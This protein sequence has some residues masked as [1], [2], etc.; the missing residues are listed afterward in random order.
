MAPAL[1]RVV[2]F[3]WFVL[4]AEVWAQEPCPPTEVSSIGGTVGDLAVDGQLAYAA[5]GAGGLLVLD[6][7]SPAEPSQLARLEIPGGYAYAL[8]LG[9]A[10]S[11]GLC[12]VADY[13]G[14]LH[15]LDVADPHQPRLLATL[16]TAFATLDVAV[17][18]DLL[19]VAEG[20]DGFAVY[21]I[22]T[23]AVPVL[24]SRVSTPGRALTVDARGSLAV[25]TFLGGSPI[26]LSIENPSSATVLSTLDA[27]EFGRNAVLADQFAY[28]TGNSSASDAD[29]W[30]FDLSDPTMPLETSRTVLRGVV[31]NLETRGD[32]LLANVF[33]YLLVLDRSEPARPRLIEEFETGSSLT[34]VA[35]FG[36]LMLAGQPG[37]VLAIESVPTPAVVGRYDQFENSLV[38]RTAPDGDRLLTAAQFQ[39]LGIDDPA[40]PAFIGR[41]A[42][43]ANDVA[44]DGRHA[45]LAASYG[46]VVVDLADPA[47]PVE[48]GFA[49]VPG[50]PSDSYRV[51][52][53]GDVVYTLSLDID[54]FAL[55]TVTTYGVADPTNPVPLGS[56]AGLGQAFDMAVR[57]D[58]IVVADGPLR[59]IDASDPTDLR[60]LGELDGSYIGVVI[61]GSVAYTLHGGPTQS[62]RLVDIADPANPTVLADVPLSRAPAYL[63]DLAIVDDVAYVV[64][65][66]VGLLRVDVKDP[67]A[68]A[69]LAPAPTAGEPFAI[70]SQGTT[71]FITTT[72]GLRILH[73]DECQPCRADLDGDGELT[74]FDFLVFQDAFEAMD[75][76][77]DF[78]GDGLLTLFDFL[79]FQNAF[80]LGCG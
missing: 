37:S 3:A 56:V 60:P 21:D 5:N 46:L 6:M 15:V 36:D 52:A 45:Y 63:H 72:Q 78:D 71:L 17:A 39:M 30:T 64:G 29:L 42:L 28:V 43:S 55:S 19:L 24:R 77:A 10:A 9:R 61:G 23:P 14:G 26:V 18:G 48:V 41:T 79:A 38:G 49:A 25:V 68:P 50:W 33:S 58:L 8:A 62:L 20:V 74:I 51:H 57:D 59:T 66:E 16:P 44:A 11:R 32:R 35:S 69:I 31:D 4:V 13:Y 54:F 12:Y 22:S 34:A 53:S 1:L 73:V 7:A 2:V 76:I 65:R 40:D 27:V 70:S 67:G 75:P 47:A 80:D